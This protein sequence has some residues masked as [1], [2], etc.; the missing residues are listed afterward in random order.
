LL[1]DL[2]AVVVMG[3]VMIPGNSLLDFF[4]QLATA[5]GN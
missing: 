3:A 2:I 1:P 4:S 5:V